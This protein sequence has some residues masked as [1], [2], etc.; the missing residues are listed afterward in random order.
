MDIDRIRTTLVFVRIHGLI[1][2]FF[3]FFLLS[4]EPTSAETAQ[5]AAY[6]P[7]TSVLS[8]GRRYTG[9]AVGRTLSALWL[10]Q[11]SM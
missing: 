4:S 11:I 8:F 5:R 2:G 6:D 1:G 7:Y 10:V 3:F 9:L